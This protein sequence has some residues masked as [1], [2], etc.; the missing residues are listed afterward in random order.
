MVSGAGENAVV[1]VSKFS[2]YSFVGIVLLAAVE[3]AAYLALQLWPL[4]TPLALPSGEGRLHI[5]VPQETGYYYGIKPNYH[6]KFRSHEFST[7]IRTN[8]RGFRMDID[9]DGD[10]LDIAIV[11]DSFT[12]G[13][14]VNVGERYG[15]LIAEAFPE[16]RV[17]TL[18]PVNGAAPADYF[19]YLKS[20]REMIPHVLVVGLFPWNDLTD[21]IASVR[22]INDQAGELV[23]IERSDITVNREGYLVSRSKAEWLE[24]WWQKRLRDFNTGRLLLIGG[25]KLVSIGSSIFGGRQALQ[26]GMAVAPFENFER[27]VLDADA[28]KSLEYLGALADLVHQRGGH[29]L[30]MYI[31]VSYMVG[32]YP[33]L[34]E[35]HSGKSP[36][37]CR[38]LKSSEDSQQVLSSWFNSRSNIEF[39]DLTDE[40]RRLERT[41]E[42]QY[43][44]IDAHW[45]EAG[46]ASAAK[47][48]IDRL[49]SRGWLRAQ[50]D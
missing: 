17:M 36:A 31:P 38:Y 26:K 8:N 9:F 47:I 16:K 19:L 14:G 25:K 35:N 45:T 23:R 30:V 2:L 11:G 40:F 43:F 20:H 28:I 22:L 49:N 6:Q 1:S 34:C 33:W 29:T 12:F 50:S 37:Q 18:A 3:A 21:D 41:G 10:P 39:V 32:D 5:F 44:E 13:H 24:P 7:D 4:A 15:D 27:G 46:H 48:L 42:R